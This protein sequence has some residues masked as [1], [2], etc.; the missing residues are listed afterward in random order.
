MLILSWYIVF[1]TEEAQWQ[2]KWTKACYL[3][4]TVWV[5]QIFPQG[6]VSLVFHCYFLCCCLLIDFFFFDFVFFSFALPVFPSVACD[7][8]VPDSFREVRVYRHSI[9]PQLEAFLCQESFTLQ[10][11]C[12]YT[13][14][15][16]WVWLSL[17]VTPA[18]SLY[19]CSLC[20]SKILAIKF[21]Y[22]SVRTTVV[23]IG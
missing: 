17:S 19:L 20:K 11:T 12:N 3:E 13:S 2:W 9:S 10:K 16:I 7:T 18:A 8:G 6:F 5:I 21:L 15:I 23:L 1:R 4:L 14:G 22:S